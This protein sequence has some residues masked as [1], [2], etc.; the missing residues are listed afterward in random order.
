MLQ[1]MSWL[2]GVVEELSDSS[3]TETEAQKDETSQ[4]RVHNT[5]QLSYKWEMGWYVETFFVH[6]NI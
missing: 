4:L 6:K 1:I 5:G 3:W 2:Y